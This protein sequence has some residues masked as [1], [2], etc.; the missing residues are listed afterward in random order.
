MTDCK[1]I[2][3][4]YQSLAAQERQIL[5]GPMEQHKAALGY[6]D[7]M[8]ELLKLYPHCFYEP[9]DRLRVQ[10]SRISMLKYRLE[11]EARG[12]T[13]QLDFLKEA[14]EFSTPTVCSEGD[15]T[16]RAKSCSRW[17]S[18]SDR[19]KKMCV[20]RL[21]AV[22]IALK[23]EAALAARH[24]HFSEALEK[25]REA[26]SIHQNIVY[27]GAEFESRE[28]QNRRLKN[29]RYL[30]YWRAVTES[31]VSLHEGDF[32]KSR[33]WLKK[34]LETARLL[35]LEG[36]FPNYFY[37]INEIVAHKFYIDAVEKVKL[38]KYAEA[39][40]LFQNWLDVGPGPIGYVRSDNIC[41][42]KMICNI[43]E[44]LREKKATKDGWDELENFVERATVARTTWVLLSRLNFLRELSFRSSQEGQRHSETFS[45]EEEVNKIAQEW[46]LFVTDTF[47]LGEDRAAG[48][49]REVNY[50][51]FLDIFDKLDEDDPKWQ[52]LL[53]QNLKHLFLIMAD[54]E[55][56]RYLCPPR[57]EAL[58]PRNEQIPL[59]SEKMT[60]DEL[61]ETILFYLNH[62]SG[63]HAY[64]FK[65]SLDQLE[66]FRLAV[67]NDDFYES[68]R[69]ER[70]IFDGIRFWPH[71]IRV[72]ELNPCRPVFIDENEPDSTAIRSDCIR[73]WNKKP[74]KIS[75]EGP[76][77]LKKGS[78]YYL[79]PKW[80]TRFYRWFGPSRIRYEQ[81]LQSDVPRL[82]DVF[83]KNVFE[84]GKKVDSRRFRDWILQFDSSER[85][86]AC[87]LFDMVKFFTED[88]M[89]EMWIRLYRER[90]PPETKIEGVAY[91][92][93]GHM[94][95]SGYYN[96]QYHLRQGMSTLKENEL[97]FEFRKA[98]REISEYD[99]EKEEKPHT[100]VFVDDF[101]G[102]GK[103]AI[104]LF[105]NRNEAYFKRHQW[106]AQAKVY[107]CAL[108]GF[109]EGINA[110]KS[111]LSDKIKDVL[112]LVPLDEKDKAFSKNNLCWKSEQER[113]ETEQWA[114]EIGRQVLTGM[115]D[116]GYD[117]D[118]D[119]LGW[120]GSQ[121]LIV[122]HYNIPNNTLPIFWGEGKRNGK[123]W[124]Q[125]WVR[126]D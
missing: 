53:M 122:F 39:R 81:F 78:Y 76:Q 9:E 32:D 31:Y 8:V 19:Q 5:T 123:R 93:L 34:T 87:R 36:C 109:R 11:R 95:K 24:F 85:L 15:C 4:E 54:Y 117:P 69:A 2:R 48:L 29:Q 98:F 56:L 16:L 42:F 43:L 73:L 6:L 64:F 17:T 70:S 92:G 90:L 46:R 18:L 101:I 67:K 45:L 25:R 82:I 100:V 44:L 65:K 88:E 118:L 120:R 119:K 13:R 47:L 83:S 40:D 107:Y 99:N 113:C 12:S 106:L 33:E 41:I 77:E 94:A 21:N 89:R 115:E 96:F 30:D 1:S 111:A 108:V 116:R 103:Q 126:Y 51:S 121:A 110:I 23:L 61:A 72:K 125:L 20:E 86:L 102:H 71:V 97:S 55:H 27:A 91:A 35:P 79:R 14:V 66:K 52:Q 49:R 22:H 59:A 105:V 7:K 63:N 124:N 74:R 75:F 38:A 37:G 80:N 84:S 57:E 26:A 28:M 60:I 112:V 3:E 58:L 114:S 68:I 62:R 50:I 10:N 104:D